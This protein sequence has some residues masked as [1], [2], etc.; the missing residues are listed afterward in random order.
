MTD[1]E[2]D[3]G[4]L[5]NMRICLVSIAKMKGIR[6]KRNLDEYDMKTMLNMFEEMEN[7]PIHRTPTQRLI[8]F[9]DDVVI[10]GAGILLWILGKIIFI[11]GKIYGGETEVK[12]QETLRRYKL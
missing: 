2:N 8:R 10:F 9:K 11:I 6:L 5:N 12:A 1:F 4:V 7:M 3:P